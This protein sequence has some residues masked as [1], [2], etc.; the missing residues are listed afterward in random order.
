MSKPIRILIV[1]NDATTLSQC[2]SFLCSLEHAA[3]RT[4]NG[5]NA[6]REFHS[7]IPDIVLTDVVMPD[8]DGIEILLEIRR[9]APGTYVVAMSGNCKSLNS[10]F[11]LHLAQNLGADGILVKPFDTHQLRRTVEPLISQKTA[12]QTEAGDECP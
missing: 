1:S 10:D 4:C 7:D 11:A 12:G 9:T 5:H 8:K 2:E 3:V 6:M